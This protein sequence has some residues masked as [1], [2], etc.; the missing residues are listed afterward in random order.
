[1][2]GFRHV[3]RAL[4]GREDY[5]VWNTLRLNYM[6]FPSPVARCLPLKVGRHIDTKGLHRGGIVFDEGVLP[7]RFMLRL[8][9]SPWPIY[10]NRSMRTYLWFHSG[11]KMIVGDEVDI[12]SGVRIVVTN[13]ATLT[14]GNHCF[15]NQNSL[16]YCSR[17]ITFGEHCTLGWDCQICDS[18]FHLLH[19]A[20]RASI[21]NPT[22]PIVIGKGVWLANHVSVGKGCTIASHSIVASHSLVCKD[23][24]VERALYAGIP[25]KL[26]RTGVTFI[27][28]HKEEARLRRRFSR[29]QCPSI[30]Y[31]V[32]DIEHTHSQDTAL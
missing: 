1:M 3:L 16:L 22:A 8:G 6:L 26:K 23:L 25:A 13:G 9:I 18:D 11:A 20:A 7:H 19:N 31:H 10:S 21:P 32:P 27:T 30:P 15:V 12:N 14:L 28:D 17:A 2:A 29:E 24:L 5:S 4:T